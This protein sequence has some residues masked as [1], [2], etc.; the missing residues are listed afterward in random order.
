MCLGVALSIPKRNGLEPLNGSLI[1]S[2]HGRA[3]DHLPN[4]FANLMVA[5]LIAELPFQIGHDLER[6]RDEIKSSL[7]RGVNQ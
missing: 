7:V 1:R 2:L 5:K 3:L 4:D 6:L